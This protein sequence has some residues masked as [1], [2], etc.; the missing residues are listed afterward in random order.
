MSKYSVGLRNV[1]SYMVSGQPYITGST[2]NAGGEVKIEF[3]FVTKNI[4]IRIPSPP[5]TAINIGNQDG[6]WLS[7]S[8]YIKGGSYLPE[9]GGSGNDFTFSWW[10][11]DTHTGP[12][13]QL[14]ILTMFKGDGGFANQLALEYN[15]NA[16]YHYQLVGAGGN[17]AV[18]AIVNDTTNGFDGNWHHI[19]ITQNDSKVYLYVDG[20]PGSNFYNGNLPAVIDTIKFGWNGGGG[21]DSAIYDEVTVFTSGF[22]QAQVSEL[23]NNGEW[24][25][26]KNHSKASSLIAWWTMGDSSPDGRAVGNFSGFPWNGAT[27]PSLG[28][29]GP[30]WFYNNGDSTERNVHAIFF[31]LADDFA[32][33]TPGPFAS[34]TTGKIR[35]SPVRALISA[36]HY[37]DESG[38]AGADNQL[39]V[40]QGRTAVMQTDALTFSFW[41]KQPAGVAAGYQRFYGTQTNG[42]QGRIMDIGGGSARIRNSLGVDIQADVAGIFDGNWHHFAMVFDPV[43]NKALMYVD[44]TEV[45]NGSLVGTESVST[46][47][48]PTT[49]AAAGEGGVQNWSELLIWTSALDSTQI[50]E[51]YNGGYVKDPTTH[52][53]SDSLQSWYRFNPN[54]SPADTTTTIYDRIGSNNATILIGG[55]PRNAQFIAGPTSAVENG[56]HYYELQ[57]YGSSI[58][59]PMKTKELYISSVNSQTTFEVIAEL[60]N[61]PTGSMY[62]LSGA[63]IDE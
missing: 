43:S 41:F 26:P 34:Q 59:L 36:I 38:V 45:V 28:I 10:M 9:V 20:N 58:D 57:G 23:Y 14:F 39:E 29:S 53:F 51:L 4:K 12:N 35:I 6:S 50:S 54:L 18:T 11:K 32:E 2:V 5:N 33:L 48:F 25:N 1:G 16:D 27:D 42:I 40:P 62:T 47:Y 7:T 8:Q 31:N 63:G 60:T 30:A 44:G 13:T 52:S 24:F 3:P 56:K 37:P 15:N 46:L 55:N 49:H 19:L 17:A 61:I 22:N 21:R